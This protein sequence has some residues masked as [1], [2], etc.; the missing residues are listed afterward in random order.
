MPP[1]SAVEVMPPP[2]PSVRKEQD[3][4]QDTPARRHPGQFTGQAPA[5]SIRIPTDRLDRVLLQA[6]EMLSAK[7]TAQQHTA[8]LRMVCEQTEEWERVWNAT[9]PT[10]RKLGYL[11][12]T[13]DGVVDDACARGVRSNTPVWAVLQTYTDAGARMPT[14]AEVRCMTYIALANGCKGLWW[15]LYQTEMRTNG[16]VFL[17]GL[18]DQYYQGGTMWEEVGQLT[19]AIKPLTP[20][21]STLTPA[22][23]KLAVKANAITHVLTDDAGTQY[24]AVVNPNT[25]YGRTVRIEVSAQ[26][27]DLSKATVVK[28]PTKKALRDVMRSNGTMSWDVQLKAGEGIFYRIR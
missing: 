17:G 1:K 25:A 21:L 22:N 16:Q 18:V 3:K 28:L 19:K 23:G 9:L 4:A 27:L 10:L 6:E 2:V 20:V 14:P 26:Q 8:D 12:Q 15:F 24:L 13:Y 7:L 5:A 11:M